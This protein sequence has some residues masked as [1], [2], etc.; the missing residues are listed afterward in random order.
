MKAK[1]EISEPILIVPE[2]TSISTVASTVVPYYG[3]RA[4]KR[5]VIETDRIIIQMI[6]D[7]QKNHL[8]EKQDWETTTATTRSVPMTHTIFWKLRIVLCSIFLLL[9]VV[10][11]VVFSEL[12]KEN[13]HN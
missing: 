3:S 11:T 2:T 4:P 12:T 10:A 6:D 13:D 9:L 7:I 1:L 8:P 5:S